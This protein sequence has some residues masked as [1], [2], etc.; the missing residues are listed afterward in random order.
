MSPRADTAAE[1][2]MLMRKTIPINEGWRFEK[3]GEAQA[4]TVDLPHT[5]NNLDG[6]DGGSDY[7]RGACRYERKLPAIERGETDRVY[8]E[9]PAAG[10]NA[11]VSVNGTA[12]VT[13]EG[14]FSQFRA[15]VTDLLTGDDTIAVIADNAERKNV[16]PQFADFTFGGGLYRG[17]NLVVVPKSHISLDDFGG[18]GVKVTPALNERM[19]EAETEVCAQITNAEPGQTLRV[20]LLDADGRV[21]ASAAADA[22]A[23]VSLRLTLKAPHLWDGVNDPYLY[24]ARISLSGE[25]EL[26]RIEIPFGVRSFSVDPQKG[27]FLN[28][29]SYPLHGVSRHQDRLDKGWAIS[30]A[31]HEE[32]MALIRE[33][34]ANTI[35]LA[36]YQHDAYFY[37]LCDR[38][39]M[40]VWAEIPYISRHV[41]EGRANTVSQM[42]ELV[43]QN[44]N[45]PSI[46]CWGLSNEITL[47]GVSDDLLENHY[48]LNDLCH[49]LDSSRLTTLAC[50]TMLETDSPLLAIPDIL[51]YNH[52]FGWYGGSVESNGPW[53][54]AFHEKH[55]DICLGLSEYGAEAI[56]RWHSDHPKAGDYSEEYQAYYHRRMLE[57]FDAR[58]YLW[59]THVWNM[60]DFAADMRD[61]G[62]V[63]GR[64]NKGLV[65]YDRKIK[66]D[67]FYLYKAWWS[68][69][70]FVH[71]AGKRFAERAGESMTIEVYSNQPHVELYAGEE[72]LEKQDGTHVFTFKVPL[73]RPGK[74]K[75]HAVADACGDR[76]EF[77]KV[78]KPNPEY[79][80]D[81]APGVATNWFDKEGKPCELE[82]P[83]GYYSI[84]DTIGDIMQSEEGRRLL[85]PMIRQAMS[86]HGGGG[87]AF[88]MTDQMREMMNGFSLE[89]MLKQAGKRF[90]AS[91]VVQLNQ[92]LNKIRK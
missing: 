14:G 40:I 88:K 32:D 68:K 78:E 62:G 49:R 20:E 77:V 45:H 10:L 39:G 25:K 5:W 91:M 48:L 8:V 70:P 2:K 36:H 80:M 85:E 44:W 42:T 81:T 15:D 64:N 43:K 12:A 56:L 57:T 22:A 4:Q 38:Y 37:D 92:A 72:L 76:A 41:P 7:F 19:T 58:P 28:G 3:P 69:E 65:T 74:I 84:R 71:I 29:R 59:S 18:S 11:E 47:N 26:D 82:F 79:S 23:E 16:Y 75:L 27:F 31:D 17:V 35:R 89:R 90:D 34:G 67:S 30:K 13:H 33:V 50:L 6:Q 9:I 63:K 51:S 60:F 86:Q 61:E 46:V 1:R 83:E 21:A 24:T 53:L 66:K 55:P 52:Y 54:D 87:A 73:E